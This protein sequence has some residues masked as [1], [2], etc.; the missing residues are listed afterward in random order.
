MIGRVNWSGLATALSQL[1]LEFAGLVGRLLR[2]GLYEPNLKLAIVC[3]A[4][5]A[6]AALVEG[7]ED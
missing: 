3:T 4:T 2:P 1:K 6:L 5:P 7:V